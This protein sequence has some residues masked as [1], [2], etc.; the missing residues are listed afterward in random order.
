MHSGIHVWC[1]EVILESV[2]ECCCAA[3]LATQALLLPL[4][5]LRSYSLFLGANFGAERG[6]NYSTTGGPYQ[7]CI[8]DGLHNSYTGQGNLKE[9]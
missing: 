6:R 7:I 2:V 5:C 9:L 1:R 3:I 4:A 8:G